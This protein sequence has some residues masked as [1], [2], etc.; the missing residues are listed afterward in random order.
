MY[1]GITSRRYKAVKEVGKIKM[2]VGVVAYYQRMQ[3]CQAEYF[4]QL[5]KPVT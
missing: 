5:L 4:R 1:I 2:S 3:I